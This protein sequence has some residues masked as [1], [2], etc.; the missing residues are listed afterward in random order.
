MPGS[1]QITDT[2]RAFRQALGLFPTG[3][4][5]VTTITDEGLPIGIA[6]NSFASVSL[7]PPLIL[8]SLRRESSRFGHFETCRHFAVNVLGDHQHALCRHFA[9]PGAGSRFD[10]IETTSGAGGVPM[11][12]DSLAC[13]ECSLEKQIEAGDHTI[14]LG[15]VTSFA[16]RSADRE[17]LLFHKGS[18][19]QIAV[20]GDQDAGDQEPP[21]RPATG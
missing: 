11:F 10:G 12:L 16:T 14:F 18:L 2:G 21:D 5:V 17:P 1:E 19:R 13:F 9:Q 8:W 15:Q 20:S 6:C 3:V 7:D 4:A